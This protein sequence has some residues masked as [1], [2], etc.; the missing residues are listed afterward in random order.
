MQALA[1][2]DHGNMFGCHEFLKEAKKHNIKP[3]IGCEIYVASSSRLRRNPKEDRTAH[4]L[5]LIAKNL[6]GYHNLCRLSSLGYTEGFY[7][8]P[9]IDKELLRKH[10]NGLIAASACMGGE[11]ARTVQRKNEEEALKVINEFRDIFG[12]DYYIEVM[13]HGAEDQKV[14]N[15]VL[16]R[17]SE[18]TGVKVVATNDI[19]FVD[20]TDYE[21][22]KVLICLNTGRE[23]GDDHG[24]HYTGQEYFKTAEEMLR[25]FPNYPEVIE[26]TMEIAGKVEH[27]NIDSKSYLLPHFPMPEGFTSENDFIRHLTYQGAQRLYPGITDTVRARID[28]ELSVI[29]DIGLSGYFLIVQDFI[30]K[31]IEMGVLVGP[32]RGSA[33]GSIVSYCLGITRLDPIFYNLHFERFL[34][35]ERIA[36]PDIDVDFDDEGRDKVVQYVVEKYG[37]KRVAQIIT[38]GT[39][40]ARSAIRDVARVLK[41]PLP[42]ADRLAKLVPDKPGTTLRSA[43]NSIP[44]LKEIY[45]SEGD[46][47]QK[48]LKYAFTLEGTVRQTGTHACGI[49]IAPGDLIDYLPVC[50]SKE[51]KLMVTQYEG[52]SVQNVGLLKMDFLGLKTLSIIK[53]ALNNIEK[54]LRVKI[55]IEN[56]SFDDEKTFELYRNGD[57][58][59]TF[60]FESDGMRRYL[61]ELKPTS[62][63]DLI[64]MNALYRPGPMEY[65]SNYIARKHGKEPV[66]YLLPVLEEVL[67]YTHGIMVY[68]EQ[69]MLAAQKIAGFTMAKADQLRY[70][71]SKKIVAQVPILR[72]EFCNGAVG[73]GYSYADASKVFDMMQEFAKY[74]FNRSHS[75]AYAIIAYQTAYLKAN[76]TADYMAAVLTH[77][78]SEIKKIAAIIDECR[79]Q[80]VKVLGPDINESELN[81]TVNKNGEIRFGLGAVKGVGEAAVNAII[82]DRSSNGPFTDLFDLVTRI[83]YR[84]VNRRC[85][86][87]F[88]KAGAFDCF[89]EIHRAQYFSNNNNDETVLIDHL[90]RYGADVQKR[91]NEMQQSLFASADEIEM[92]RLTIPS[93]PVWSKLEQLKHEKEVTGFYMSGHPL[94]DCKLEY[95]NLCNCSLKELQNPAEELLIKDITFAGIVTSVTTKI[96]K[97]GKPYCTLEIE[98]FD[99]QFSIVLFSEDYLRWKHLLNTDTSLLFKGRFKSRYDQTDR[100]ELRISNIFLLA[101]AFDKLVKELQIELPLH[102]LDVNLIEKLNKLIRKHN[103]NC[104]LRFMVY[105]QS[106]GLSLTLLAPKSLVECSEILKEVVK[107]EGVKY[108]LK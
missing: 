22:H 10:S 87:V 20:S 56:L 44:E 91:R 97:N 60:Q 6:T 38:F 85:M 103:G 94:D 82:A 30:S 79:H 54:R 37:E 21:A 75:A 15:R 63:E 31:A 69:I 61:R 59:G 34:N 19:H 47:T 67:H 68:Q 57:T 65:I 48:I 8:S 14:L 28:Y 27:Y 2:T 43:I 106:N 41:L 90:M 53:E 5:I 29:A 71:M 52:D 100:L 9:R 83:N 80:N 36:L 33:T 102:L 11:L 58:I 35:P 66:V 99:S 45:K 26:N 40:Q 51:S 70:V 78:L 16:F 107:I 32:G 18:T 49:V 93:C 13:D 96:A 23:T 98:D 7:Y 39:M 74:G 73:K 4:H 88:A 55:D 104:S 101:E 89:K 77:N 62:I 81:F 86:E 1:I 42:E 95:I 24:L 108:S 17:L 46:L 50:T 92:P 105:D 12:D 64:A 84:T 72:E 76:F 25:L 3:L